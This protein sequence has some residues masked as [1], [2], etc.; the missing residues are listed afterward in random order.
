MPIAPAE[1]EAAPSHSHFDSILCF[2]FFFF[3][4]FPGA[5]LWR[6]AQHASPS[7]GAFAPEKLAAVSLGDLT[8][9]ISGLYPGHAPGGTIDAGETGGHARS[10]WLKTHRELR[11]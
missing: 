4:F 9:V 6:P 1:I 8:K 10:S 2:L 7:P 5:D 3:F 11:R